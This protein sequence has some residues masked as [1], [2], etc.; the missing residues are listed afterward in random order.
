MDV[1]NFKVIPGGKYWTKKAISVLFWYYRDHEEM[2]DFM[3]VKC[4]NG[5][6]C[7]PILRK[8]STHV[9]RHFEKENKYLC[10]HY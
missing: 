9:L 5:A 1:I 4:P 8:V 3:K 7:L 10:I 6:G 2:C